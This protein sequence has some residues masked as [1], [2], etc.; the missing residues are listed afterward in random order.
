MTASLRSTTGS[1]VG[2]FAMSPSTQTTNNLDLDEW[3]D[4]ICFR[5]LGKL[6]A[7]GF[8]PTPISANQLSLLTGL[9]GIIAGVFYARP[10]VSSVWGALFVVLMMAVDCADGELARL[11]KISDW[12]G[13]GM[14]GVGDFSASIGLQ[15]G[16]LIGFF[17]SDFV[18]FDYRPSFIELFILASVAAASMI[19]NAGALDNV[20]QRL[21]PSSIDETLLTQAPTLNGTG[22]K[23]LYW[24]LKRYILNAQA[25]AGT[26][27]PSDYRFLRRIQWVGP[28][29][30]NTAIALS[31]LATLF[32]P[33]AH[34]AYYLYAI[35]PCNLYMLWARHSAKRSDAALSQPYK[36]SAYTA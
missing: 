28:T 23:I 5:P 11:R 10:G 19:W 15:L 13:R 22:D 20:K 14:D 17:R 21:R 29:H 12:R 27:C 34:I 2:T 4:A 35:I 7:L 36:G 32:Y 33:Q 24:M 25:M 3:A 8:E 31:G 30:H 1:S 16:M 26:S 9:L 6:I 18:I